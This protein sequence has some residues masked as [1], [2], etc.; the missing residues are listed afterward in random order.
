MVENLKNKE[1]VTG[2][3]VFRYQVE[4]IYLEMS[5]AIT[6]VAFFKLYKKTDEPNDLNKEANTSFAAAAVS[7]A[8]AYA[9]LEAFCNGQL[10]SKYA[11]ISPKTKEAGCNGDLRI[12]NTRNTLKTK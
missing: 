1:L 6:N 8:F 9:A 3:Q 10:H 5:R 4:Q 7:I 12:K 11:T 2:E